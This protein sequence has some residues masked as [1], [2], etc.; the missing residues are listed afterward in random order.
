MRILAKQRQLAD[1]WAMPSRRTLHYQTELLLVSKMNTVPAWQRA[2][3]S[4]TDLELVAQDI[5]ASAHKYSAQTLAGGLTL[6]MLA[7]PKFDREELGLQALTVLSDACPS[8]R[9]KHA[10]AYDMTAGSLELGEGVNRERAG[11]D[12][13]A[14]L[15]FIRAADRFLLLGAEEGLVTALT[16]AAD[17]IVAG[18]ASDLAQ[19]STWCAL[20]A[21]DV[22]VLSP[23]SAGTALQRLIRVVIAHQVRHGTSV[24]ELVLLLQAA[25]GRRFS[26]SLA[27]GSTGWSPTARIREL[28]HQEAL[29]RAQMPPRRP[30]LALPDYETGLDEEDVLVAYSNE[31]ETSPADDD[32]G[33]LVNLR[34]G[35]ERNIASSLMPQMTDV[36]QPALLSEIRQALEPRTALVLLYD[37]QWVTGELATFGIVITRTTEYVS[38][39]TEPFPFPFAPIGLGSGGRKIYVPSNGLSVAELRRA[40]QEEPAPRAVSPEAAESLAHIARDE[41]RA[42]TENLDALRAQGITHL[43]I[44]PHGAAH[45]SPLHM[46]GEDGHPLAEEM[47]VTYITNLAQLVS[48]TKTPSVRRAGAAVFGLSYHDEPRLPYLDS[49]EQE[50]RT[51]ADVL[52][53]TPVLDGAATESLFVEAL[54]SARWVHLRAHGRHDV[55]APMFQTVF[56]SPGD[57]DDG[58]LRAYEV[59]GLDLR[60][61]ELVTLGACQTALGRIDASDNLSGLPAALLL[62][63]AKA[64]IG[65]LWEVMAEASTLFFTTLYR[66]L[67][68]Q[69]FDVVSAFGAAQAQ[70]R[71]QFPEYRDWGAFYLNGGCDLRGQ[72]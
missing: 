57:G 56:L 36:T 55:D 62:A 32:E 27:T 21:L 37:G 50:A 72:S 31:Y 9:S 53:T 2:W 44:S 20:Q 15:W 39:G 64:V 45:F 46:A 4:S 35:I 49:S 6:L 16:Y 38:V 47:T 51:I 17:L 65:T 48:P 12:T 59:L 43:L 34:R 42:V 30:L 3:Q 1:Q 68:R 60:G 26:A 11:D 10:E 41:M 5:L 58:Q 33:R 28:L 40:V 52:G 14:I 19:V 54:Q 61:L 8:E 13:A 66:C 69:D 63:G 23:R 7:S 29:L 70:T 22:E 25:K 24:E 67:T 18:K 71:A